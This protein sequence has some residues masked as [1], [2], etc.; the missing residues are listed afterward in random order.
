[1]SQVQNMYYEEPASYRLQVA[2]MMLSHRLLVAGMTLAH[3]LL[4]DGMM[5]SHWLLCSSRYNPGTPAPGSRCDAG[6]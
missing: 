5:L 2:G 4:V 6:S 1:M 3:W